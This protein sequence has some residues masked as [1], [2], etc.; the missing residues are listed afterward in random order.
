V[1]FAALMIQSALDQFA[2]LVI[3]HGNLMVA[4][5]KITSYNQ[6]RSAPFSEPWSLNGY[7]VYSTEGADAVI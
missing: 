4:R 1:G 7:Q 2:G 6:H 5:V 3:G